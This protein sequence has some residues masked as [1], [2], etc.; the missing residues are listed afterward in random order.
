MHIGCYR[1]CKNTGRNLVLK[2]E[3]K[4]LLAGG[5]NEYRSIPFWS[6]NNYLDEKVEWLSIQDMIAA[7]LCVF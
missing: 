2:Q 7:R 5:L 1:R 4:E 3:V 6:W